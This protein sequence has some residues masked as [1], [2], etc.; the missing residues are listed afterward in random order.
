MIPWMVDQKRVELT[1]RTGRGSAT[2]AAQCLDP[3]S[4]MVETVRLVSD[5][6]RAA[7]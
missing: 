5:P 6:R 1:V 2:T 4:R 3:A 7:G